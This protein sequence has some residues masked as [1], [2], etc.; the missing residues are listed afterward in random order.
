MAARADQEA[1]QEAVGGRQHGCL[2]QV[3]KVDIPAAK[4][5]CFQSGPINSTLYQ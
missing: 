4:H 2:F 3:H 1:D 5:V